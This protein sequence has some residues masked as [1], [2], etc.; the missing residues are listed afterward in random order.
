MAKFRFGQNSEPKVSKFAL[1]KERR[2]TK[3]FRF[4][5]VIREI[6][7]DD[8]MFSPNDPRA[9]GIDPLHVADIQVNLETAGFDEDGEL[10]SFMRHPDYPG[11]WIVIDNHHLIDALK[12][13][14][15]KKWIGNEYEYT[16]SYGENHMWAAATELGFGIN[17]DHNPTK[18]TTM[19]SV[20]CAA[21]KKIENLGYIHEPGTPVDADHIKLWMETCDHTKVFAKGK[22]T[23][24]INNILN[25]TAQTGKKI[26]PLTL[27]KISAIFDESNGLYGTGKLT[28][29]RWGFLKKTDN[30]AADGPKAYTEMVG[31][32]EKGLTPVFFTYSGKDDANKIVDNHRLF[33]DKVYDTYKKHMASVKTFHGISFPLLTKE[34]VFAKIEIVAIGQIDGE[35]DETNFIDR[36]LNA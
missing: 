31:Q 24:M 14:G 32:L 33:F 18:K 15:Q 27:E 21:L 1:K 23:Q 3:Y 7:M 34:E 26:R 9:D 13:M 22:I 2:N 11:K 17:N 12:K 36:P 6:D 10:S 8:I 28:N 30:Y 5:K 4:V 20:E 19:S 16:G 25:P 35:Y 29:N